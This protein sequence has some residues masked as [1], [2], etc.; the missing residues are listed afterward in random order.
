MDIKTLSHTGSHTSAPNDTGA[1]RSAPAPAPQGRPAVASV[2]PQAAI[3]QPDPKAAIE[4]INQ[5]LE[6]INKTMQSLSADLEFVVDAETGRS[7]VKVTD[8]Q[9]G[10]IIRQMPSKEAL[11]I[12]Q[13][14]DKV[15]GLLIRQKA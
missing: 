10:E 2:A 1:F 11:E 8:K 14:L 3:R 5:A 6:S 9:T 7:V 15:Q 13:A 4:Q 12:A